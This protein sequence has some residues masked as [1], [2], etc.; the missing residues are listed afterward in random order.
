M[1]AAMSSSSIVND[2]CAIEFATTISIGS[3]SAI[4]TCGSICVTTW[5]TRATSAVLL[6]D[7]ARTTKCM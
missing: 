6:I 3:T 1:P 7:G 2:V 5:R 4:G